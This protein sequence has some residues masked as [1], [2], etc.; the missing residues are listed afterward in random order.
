M[1]LRASVLRAWCTKTTTTRWK[2]KRSQ[3]RYLTTWKRMWPGTTRTVTRTK[4]PLKSRCSNKWRDDRA[5]SRA[6]HQ[7]FTGATARG[8]RSLCLKMTPYRRS[9]RPTTTTTICRRHRIWGAVGAKDS[10]KLKIRT[11]LQGSIQRWPSSLRQT[12]APRVQSSRTR[13]S[14]RRSVPRW[15]RWI[16]EQPSVGDSKVR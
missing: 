6:S 15:R 11:S 13:A 14:Q 12:R 9:P 8:S 3:R 4:K 10:R 1:M 5:R 16:W 2:S 7:T